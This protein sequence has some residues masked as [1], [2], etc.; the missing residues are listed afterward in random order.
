[1][2]NVEVVPGQK[3]Q[4]AKDIQGPSYDTFGWVATE[5]PKVDYLPGGGNPLQSTA[6]CSIKSWDNQS[7]PGSVKTTNEINGGKS[8]QSGG[9]T[10]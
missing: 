3:G 8:M 2:P 10:G 1:M 7:E 5:S 6:P 9:G 4:P